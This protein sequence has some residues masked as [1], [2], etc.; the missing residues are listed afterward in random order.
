M[1]GSKNQSRRDF[2]KTV[3]TV[4][5]ISATSSNNSFAKGQSDALSTSKVKFDNIPRISL[6]NFPTACKKMSHLTNELNGPDIYIKRDD[7]MELAHG[8]NKTRKLEYALAAALNSGAK[9]VITQGGLQSNHVRQTVSGAAMVGLECHV[10]LSNPVPEMKKELMSS[11]NY[12]MDIIMGA[13]VY[14]AEGGRSDLIQKVKDD[15]TAQGKN[16]YMIPSG[17]SNGIGSIGYMN[18]A[19]ELI[20][21]WQEMNINPSHIFTA[22]GSCGTQAGLIMGL[23]YF[24][25]TTTKVVGVSIG[26]P[27]DG[28]KAKVRSVLNEICDVIDVDKTFIHDDDI[29][30]NDDYYGKA[31]G[32]PTEAGIAAI[33]LVGGKE[34]ILLDPVYTSKNMSGLIDMVKNKKLDHPK[35]IVFL[36]TGGAPALH[37]YASYFL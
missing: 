14:V 24:G 7:V 30:V 22:S 3:S 12:L 20:A 16:P 23:R 9:A 17:A 1:H 25:N 19:R 11:G 34:G 5:L 21:Q 15:L 31:Y 13:H 32:Y 4:A 18:A 27:A 26:G 8:G 6:T 36:H 33:K 29:I 35:D 2:I 28:V 10:I 37:P